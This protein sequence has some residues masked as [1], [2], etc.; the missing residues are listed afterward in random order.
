MV[1]TVLDTN[2]VS[3]ELIP[4]KKVAD[5]YPK[6]IVTMDEIPMGEDGIRQINIVGF[7]ISNLKDER[8]LDE[9]QLNHEADKYTIINGY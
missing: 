3:R 5:N 8:M 7:L 1:V 9:S 6:Y 4:L 2:T